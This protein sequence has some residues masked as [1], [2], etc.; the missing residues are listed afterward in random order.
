MSERNSYVLVYPN[1]R[2]VRAAMGKGIDHATG[3]NPDL[4]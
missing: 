2:I 3:V 1:P 4:R